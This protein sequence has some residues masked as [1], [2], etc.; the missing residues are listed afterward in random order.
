MYKILFINQSD[1]LSRGRSY[2]AFMSAYCLARLGHKVL[3]VCDRSQDFILSFYEGPVYDI[4]E[5][6]DDD[7]EKRSATLQPSLYI[8]VLDPIHRPEKIKDFV[9]VHGGKPDMIWYSGDAD[10]C[11]LVYQIVQ[12]W[13]VPILHS[14]I[15]SLGACVNEV[16]LSHIMS[17]PP[18]RERRIISVHDGL[19]DSDMKSLIDAAESAGCEPALVIIGA[20]RGKYIGDHLSAYKNLTHIPYTSEKGRF[21]MIA[22]SMLYAHPYDTSR[23]GLIAEAIATGTPVATGVKCPWTPLW[24]AYGS[25]ID[26]RGLDRTAK[27]FSGADFWRDTSTAVRSYAKKHFGFANRMVALQRYITNTLGD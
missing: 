15:M 18:V 26:H 7:I 10:I 3:Y 27:Y 23:H 4:D 16:Q 5:I 19:C 21:K 22:A 13:R 14:D 25:S 1:N 24:E 12:A 17:R 2:D 9:D 6:F 8:A 11:S 20:Y